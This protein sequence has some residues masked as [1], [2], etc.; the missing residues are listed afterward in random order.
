MEVEKTI[1]IINLMLPKFTKYPLPS[2]SNYNE[3]SS[4]KL[5][6]YLKVMSDAHYLTR[7]ILGFLFGIFVDLMIP[8]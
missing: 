8:I 3:S 5:D 7:D 1:E 4:Y 6:T 2:H